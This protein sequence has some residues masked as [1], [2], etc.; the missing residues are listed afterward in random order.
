MFV[1]LIFKFR[2]FENHVLLVVPLEHKN[3]LIEQK[4]KLILS[5]KEPIEKH[6]TK[7]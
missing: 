2:M 4:I 7:I 3:R 5:E 6:L 1:E